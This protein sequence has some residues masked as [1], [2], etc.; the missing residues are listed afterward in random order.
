M[1]KLRSKERSSNLE[2]MRILL[3]LLIIMHHYVV[4][5]G[6]TD[7][8]TLSNLTAN[9]IFL[10]Y[11][12]MWGKT[13]INA[14]I[15]ISGFFLC[16]SQLTWQKYVKLL[17]QIIFYNTVI[18]LLLLCLGYATLSPKEVFITFGGIFHYIGHGFT[19]SFMAFYIFV[20]ILNKLIMNIDCGG[21]K[22]SIGLA[23]IHTGHYG[24][25]LF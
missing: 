18:Y 4:N 20:P 2:L 5:S 14:F 13:A 8:M 24:H 1:D 21:G 22:T 16:I 25:I 6:A 10:Q 15:L 23:F 7:G 17:F 12:G 19:S 3:M 11:W 9:S